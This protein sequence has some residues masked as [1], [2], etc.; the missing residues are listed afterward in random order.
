MSK[1]LRAFCCKYIFEA[2]G[3]NVNIEK[4]VRFGKGYEIRIG[5]NSGIGINNVVPNN[6]K[7]GENVMIGPDVLML[8]NNHKFDNINKPM[9][10]QG[11]DEQ[12]EI[13]IGDDVWIGQR[14]IITPGKKIGNGVIIGTGSVVSKNIPDYAIAAGNPIKI[15]RF[16]NEQ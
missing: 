4:G 1:R 11:L 14:V 3:N 6:V 9:I 7:I 5:N 15:I 16:R 2:C 13:I 12:K 10:Q 8:S